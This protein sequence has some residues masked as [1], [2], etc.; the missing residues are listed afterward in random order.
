LTA[1]LDRLDDTSAHA[2]AGLMLRASRDADAAHVLIHAFPDGR[3]LLGWRNRATAPSWKSANWRGRNC[4]C[5]SRSSART[6]CCRWA[7]RRMAAP[8]RRNRCRST[9]CRTSALAGLAVLAHA[10]NEYLTT[11]LFQEIN[12]Q[13]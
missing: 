5:T 10:E 6:A 2:K 7:T 11:A 4:R 12:L 9:A 8:G 3:I 1:R 13:R